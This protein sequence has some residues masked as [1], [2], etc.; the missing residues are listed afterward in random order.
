MKLPNELNT[1]LSTVI[2]DGDP[3]K[4]LDSA[5][6]HLETN[7][8]SAAKVHQQIEALIANGEVSLEDFGSLSNRWFG[9]QDEAISWLRSL[10]EALTPSKL[11]GA[12]N[13]VVKDSN[14]AVLSEGDS[15]LVIKDLKVKGGSSD[16]KRGT[17]IRRI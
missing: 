5:R 16:L 3:E 10:K 12:N 2:A 8:A 17:L 15:V 6:N 11:E 9:E 13:L 1:F 4:D 14:G 7:S